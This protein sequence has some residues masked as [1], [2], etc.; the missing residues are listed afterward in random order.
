M[1]F[2]LKTFKRL[3]LAVNMEKSLL[4]PSQRIEWLGAVWDTYSRSAAL[5]QKY[6]GFFW[7]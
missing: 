2:V 1:E 5:T 6:A 3:G 7:S 4:Y